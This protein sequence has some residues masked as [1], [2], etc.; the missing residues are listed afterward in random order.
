MT[1]EVVHV[2]NEQLLR[3]NVREWVRANRRTGADPADWAA[4][5]AV[6]AY[7]D[8]ASVAEA[9]Q[10]ARDFVRCWWDHPSH[11]QEADGELVTLA[12]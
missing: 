5:I 8:G 12:S 10:T 3:E 11:W 9:C 6:G 7:Q 2:R 1:S 4:A